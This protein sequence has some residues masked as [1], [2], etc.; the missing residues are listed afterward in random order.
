MISEKK[1]SK[2]MKGEE[3]ISKV[4]KGEKKIGKA[5]KALVTIFTIIAILSSAQLLYWGGSAV[6]VL[7]AV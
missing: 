5:Q 1:I 7:C 4:M 3:R 6:S 2:A